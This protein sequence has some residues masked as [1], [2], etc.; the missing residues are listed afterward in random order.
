M[1]EGPDFDGYLEAQAL[2]RAKAGRPVPFFTP[3]PK[4][5]PEGT[6]LGLNGE[7]LDPTVQPL[8]SGFASASVICS[9]SS[10]PARGAMQPAAEHSEIGILPTSHIMLGTSV[11]EYDEAE[12]WAAT[13]LETFATRYKIESAVPDQIG[14][15][16]PQ[17]MLIFGER[18]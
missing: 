7:P 3:L 15:G 14:P 12:L 11:A 13:E 17:R 2:L 6:Q 1:S 10:R 9:V 18:M 5:W 16:P 4:E 8:A